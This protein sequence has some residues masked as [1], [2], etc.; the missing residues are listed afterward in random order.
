MPRLDYAGARHH[1]MNHGAGQRDVFLDDEDRSFFC[2]LLAHLPNRFHVR[3]HGYALMG[4][5][6]HLLLESVGG[7]LPRAMRHI[8][9]RFSREANRRRGTDGPLFRSRYKNR[10]VGT[11]SYWRHLLVYVHLNPERAHLSPAETRNWTSHRAYMGQVERPTWLHTAELQALFD[12]PDAYLSYYNETLEGRAK[13]P[14]DFDAGRLW[15]RK[16]TG[17]V[18]VP[19]MSAPIGALAAA[20]AEVCA[21][22]GMSLEAVLAKPRG[23]SGN[24]ANW[25]A[26]WW[27]SR[28]R[29][30]PHRRI[31]AAL[32]VDH[33][34]VSQ[35]IRR[36]EERQGSDPQLVVWSQALRASSSLT[37][38]GA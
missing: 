27:L 38:G 30:M 21:A 13:A 12:G 1:V 24:K 34:G 6:Y 9:A 8:G 29:G 32:G 7:Q 18:D 10:L 36:V 28:G 4:N 33:A 20:L 37:A 26:A 25:L 31:A 15:S 2:D 14:K 23:R 16:S 11:D 22:T 3:V 19:D 5:H 17:A 35:R